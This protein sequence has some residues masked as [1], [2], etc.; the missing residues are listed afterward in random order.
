M[1]AVRSGGNQR[2]LRVEESKDLEPKVL[3]LSTPHARVGGLAAGVL[4]RVR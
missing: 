3:S 4:G 2:G 1:G